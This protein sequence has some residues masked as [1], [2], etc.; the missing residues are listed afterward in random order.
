MLEFNS[1][2]FHA[3]AVVITFM[4]NVY[5]WLKLSASEHLIAK[6]LIIVLIVWNLYLLLT[7]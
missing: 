3:T 7:T 1:I 2:I 4:R 6:K 5:V